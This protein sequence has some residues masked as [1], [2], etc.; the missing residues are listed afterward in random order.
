M[1]KSLTVLL[2]FFLCQDCYAKTIVLNNNNFVSLV[3]P[4]TTNSVDDVIKSFK[5]DLNGLGLTRTNKD[6]GGNVM[7]CITYCFN[8]NFI[9]A[10]V[11]AGQESFILLI[12]FT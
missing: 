10:G 12:S 4:V 5:R 11:Q 8:R 9:Y 1:F 3:G 6:G 2:S 7:S